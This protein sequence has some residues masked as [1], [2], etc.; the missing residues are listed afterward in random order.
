M[1]VK[2]NEEKAKLAQHGAELASLTTLTTT[3]EIKEQRQELEELVRS[4]QENLTLYTEL[5][6]PVKMG[7]CEARHIWVPKSVGLVGCMPWHDVYGDWLRILVD[8]VVGVRGHK[9]EG[10][11]L[12]VER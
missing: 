7:V 1:K 5:L 8:A 3:T 10:P 9:N 12:K 11:V 6:E 2:I 4:A